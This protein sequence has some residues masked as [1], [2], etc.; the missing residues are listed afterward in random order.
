[1]RVKHVHDFIAFL[2]SLATGVAFSFMY[3]LTISMGIF[4]LCCALWLIITSGLMVVEQGYSLDPRIARS[5]V[6]GLLLLISAI[7]IAASME[8]DIRLTSLIFI[9]LMALIAVYVYVL[10]KKTQQGAFRRGLLAQSS[11][12]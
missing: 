7:V 5:S 6:G 2:A 8:L 3:P 11:K 1:M 9:A 4:M 12:K 10:S